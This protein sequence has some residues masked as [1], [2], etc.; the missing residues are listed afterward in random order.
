MKWHE[1]MG[2]RHQMKCEPLTMNLT[3]IPHALISMIRYSNVWVQSD[4]WFHLVVKQFIESI[5]IDLLIRWWRIDILILGEARW[6]QCWSLRT[7]MAFWEPSRNIETINKSFEPILTPTT[8]VL[9]ATIGEGRG[10]S[11]WHAG[12]LAAGRLA[13]WLAGWLANNN[14]ATIKQ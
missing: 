11:L 8:Y 9:M 2:V 1:I 6:S 13:G 7:L 12:W 4:S 14:R 5:S 3:V 10:C